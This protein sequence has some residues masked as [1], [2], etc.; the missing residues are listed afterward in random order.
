MPLTKS[1]SKVMAN[2]TK[3]YGAKKGKEVFYASINKG[4]PGSSKWHLKKSKKKRGFP[5]D[6]RRYSMA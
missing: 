2:M 5:K 4:K 3:E 6:K 1:G